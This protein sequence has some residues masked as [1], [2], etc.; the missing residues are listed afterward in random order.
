MGDGKGFDAGAIFVSL[1]AQLS[2]FDS[3][4]ASAKKTLDSLAESGTNVSKTFQTTG[5]AV[6]TAVDRIGARTTQT[7]KTFNDLESGTTKVRQRFQET[8]AQTEK[9]EQTTSRANATWAR[10]ANRILSV[11]L[12]LLSLSEHSGPFKDLFQG[13]SNGVSA[14]GAAM[15]LFQGKLT[16]LGGGFI[17][18][19]VAIESFI[20][21]YWED[22]IKAQDEGTDQMEASRKRV[23]QMR[24]TLED[25]ALAAKI[26]GTTYGEDLA[27]KLRTQ[28]ATFASNLKR[29]R[30]ISAELAKLN[31]ADPGLFGVP[32]EAKIES[33]NQERTG[34]NTQQDDISK[35]GAFN[36][37]KANIVNL[38]QST[39]DLNTA[40]DNTNIIATRA[41]NEGISSPAEVA[42]RHLSSAK[43]AFDKLVEDNLKILDAANA[44]NVSLK[45][46]E[47]LLKR[48]HTDE[49]IRLAAK[50][51]KAEQELNER[52]KAT[53]DLAKTFSTSVGD[54]LREAIINSQKPMEALATIGK[55]LFANM[56]DQTIKRLETGLSAAFTA[57]TGAA[58][59]GIGLAL[60]GILG[61]GG[62]ILSRLGAKS[63]QSFNPVNSAVTSTQAFRGV[64]AGQASVAIADVGDNLSRAVQPV[65]DKLTDVVRILTSIDSKTGRAVGGF[66]GFPAVA[67]P[68]A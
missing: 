67:A 3:G 21:R 2:D 37:A 53:E 19:G 63:S 34:L 44:Y 16:G 50:K 17:A 8:G 10:S 46:R 7:A 20:F 15:Q 23:D 18:A 58:G 65:V 43:T 13:I 25:A 35:T 24:Q 61:V 57:I 4:I 32:K 27:L 14:A 56:V 45:D 29:L 47:E 48:L 59:E 52:I 26:F 51:V 40:L 38:L 11:Q 42:A 33:L 66:S 1:K 9:L 54:G 55:N 39:K 31:S 28:E 49:E 6:A 22:F 30:E 5:T 64:V 41:F 62:A 12:A 60:S 36:K 68:T